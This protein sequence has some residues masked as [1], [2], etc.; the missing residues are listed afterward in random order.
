MISDWYYKELEHYTK[1]IT[2]NEYG[3]EEA[4]L[5]RVTS[6]Y[7]R[8][9]VVR[10]VDYSDKGPVVTERVYVYTSYGDIDEDDVIKDGDKVYKIEEKKQ[11]VNHLGENIA[12][13]YEVSEEEN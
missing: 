9:G 10:V 5:V 4:T 6:F 8:I 2:K 11:L 7:G 3:E 12:W 1:E 13:R